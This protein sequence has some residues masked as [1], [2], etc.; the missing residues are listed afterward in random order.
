V[1]PVQLDHIRAM[2]DHMIRYFGVRAAAK[3]SRKLK[4]APIVLP[5]PTTVR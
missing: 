4:R 3:Q 1:L 2:L 5:N